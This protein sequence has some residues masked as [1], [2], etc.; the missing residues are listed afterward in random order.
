VEYTTVDFSAAP[1]A[2]GASNAEALGVT[3][4]A[5]REA[6]PTAGDVK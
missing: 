2:F 5:G 4:T 3:G 6:A 1:T